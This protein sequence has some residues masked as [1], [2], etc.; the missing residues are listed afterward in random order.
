MFENVK[1]LTKL[2]KQ[3]KE[4]KAKMKDVQESLKDEKIPASALDGKIKVVI[5]GELE[6]ISL[7]IDE[8]LL[9]ADNKELVEKGLILAIGTAIKNAKD[10]AAGKLSSISGGM[11]IPGL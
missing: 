3:A 1:D 6:I 7:N 10:S 9:A 2:F 8:S 4:M 5:T 11:D